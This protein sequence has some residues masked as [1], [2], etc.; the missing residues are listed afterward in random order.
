MD[1]INITSDMT[2]AQVDKI[3]AD[4]EWQAHKALVNIENATGTIDHNTAMMKQSQSFLDGNI[5]ET[6]RKWFSSRIKKYQ[7]AINGAKKILEESHIQKTHG[8]QQINACIAE[9][10]KRGGWSRFWLVKSSNG[11]VHRNKSCTT[12]FPTTVYAWVTDLSGSTDEEV[13]DLAGEKACTVC[14]PDAPVDALR[15]P[16]RIEDPERREARLERERKAAEKAA[17]KA[18]KAITAP[19]GSAL[20]IKNS[21]SPVKTEAEAQ[22]VY[23]NG[24]ASV[25]LHEAGRRVV[26][27]T[28][29]LE[30]IIQD[31]KV[32]L[33]ALAHKRDTSIPEQQELLDVKAKAKIKRDY[34]ITL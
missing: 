31:N 10:E 5:N 29:Y 19:D 7:E 3:Q 13:V 8:T 28:S 17:D 20:R 30:K 22:R 24:R 18:R 25:L 9:Y 33:E 26:Q 34:K 32:L 12:C 2:P 16:S 15:R 11:H 6:D 1:I 21:F 27:N 4:A 14:F 23:L